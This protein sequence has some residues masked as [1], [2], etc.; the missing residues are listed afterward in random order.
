MPLT[1]EQIAS[2]KVGQQLRLTTQPGH[3]YFIDAKVVVMS[4]GSVSCMVKITEILDRGPGNMIIDGERIVA[5]YAELSVI[6]S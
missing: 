6:S 3:D 1:D 4:L 5:T 2:L